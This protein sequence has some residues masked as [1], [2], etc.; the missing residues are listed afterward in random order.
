M[1]ITIDLSPEDTAFVEEQAK[2][3]NLTAEAFSKAAVMKAARNAAYMESIRRAKK[4]L[5]EGKG[6][7]VTDE[8]LRRIVYGSAV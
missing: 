7:W 8:E 2:T 3:E 5:D 4:N 6:V 1:S